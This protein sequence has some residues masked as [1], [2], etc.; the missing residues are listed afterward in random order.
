MV[1]HNNS[2][3]ARNHRAARDSEALLWRAYCDSGSLARTYLDPDCVVINPLVH[4]AGSDAPLS[5]ES[6]PTLQEALGR[7][8]PWTTYRMFKGEGQPAVV[9]VDMMAVCIMY[10]VEVRRAPEGGQGSE[11]KAEEKREGRVT[12]IWR[13]GA[14]GDYRLCAQHVAVEGG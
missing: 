2:I 9:E 4:P 1:G 11:E 10:R 3:R 14:G 5:A 8:T 13:Q 12:S 7:M 6:E